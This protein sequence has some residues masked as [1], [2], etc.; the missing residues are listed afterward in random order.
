MRQYPVTLLL[1]VSIFVVFAFEVSIQAI[2]NDT[3]LLSLGGIPDSGNMGAGYWRLLTFAWLHTGYY[4]LIANTILL[5]WV[6]RIIERRLRSFPMLL[7][8]LSCVLLGG[9]LIAWHT[10]NHPKPGISLGAS[11][12]VSGLLG[13]A[14][15]LL[16]RPS[17]S[18]YGQPKWL[19]VVL[20]V[21]PWN[22]L[23]TRG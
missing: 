22:L 16:Y 12:G 2:G 4:H 21:S 23:S 8:Y 11:A 20:L 1:V 3:L 5:F 19:R 7:I 17:A 15:V 18:G 13:C 6:G 14:V 9:M 10:S